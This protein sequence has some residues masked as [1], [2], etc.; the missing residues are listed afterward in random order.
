VT[1]SLPLLENVASLIEPPLCSYDEGSWLHAVLASTE[2]ELLLDLHNVHANACN[3][4]FSARDV[5]ESLPG[6][7]I[8]AIHLAGGRRIERGRVLDD[9]LHDVPDE[10]FALLACVPTRDAM[11]ILERDG[12]YPAIEE[13]MAELDRARG[14]PVSGTAG[15]AASVPPRR[16]DGAHSAGETPAL[17]LL[18]LLYTD[19]DVRERFLA[20]PE[21][22]APSLAGIDKDDLQLAARSF[23]KKRAHR[24]G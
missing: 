18:A 13:L 5:V 8:R 17:Q 4:G 7:R 14:T 1:G 23:A 16:R 15:Q 2:C 10:V 19:D 24:A 3:F 11:V 6:E 21:S 12:N 9:H 22:V 20:D